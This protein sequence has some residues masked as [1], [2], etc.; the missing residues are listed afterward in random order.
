M[1]ELVVLEFERNAYVSNQHR[2]E[3]Q[4]LKP[5]SLWILEFLDLQLGM[6][7][8]LHLRNITQ[9]VRAHTTLWQLGL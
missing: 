8:G 5:V 6:L 7:K 1:G 3:G 4:D 2:L 9:K